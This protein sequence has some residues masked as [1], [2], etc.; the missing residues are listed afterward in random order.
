MASACD[1]NLVNSAISSA[2]TSSPFLLAVSILIFNLHNSKSIMLLPVTESCSF[3]HSG[4]SANSSASSMALLSNFCDTPRLL[5]SLWRARCVRRSSLAG[6]LPEFSFFMS[7][8]KGR[9]LSFFRLL[10]RLALLDFLL[11]RRP[12]DPDPAPAPKDPLE[13]LFSRKNSIGGSSDS[14]KEGG[15]TSGENS[16]LSKKF[17]SYLTLVPL[18]MLC[19]ELPDGDSAISSTSSSSYSPTSPLFSFVSAFDSSPPLEEALS[20]CINIISCVFIFSKAPLDADRCSFCTCRFACAKSFVMG[21]SGRCSAV[22]VSIV[23]F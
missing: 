19:S 4:A 6:P 15:S 20:I 18:L 21:F 13:P 5:F 1:F 11:S 10:P 3:I 2:L 16:R 8:R 12:S 14:Q 22:S 9:G 17:T 23:M 7:S